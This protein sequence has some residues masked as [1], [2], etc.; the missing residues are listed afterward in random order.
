MGEWLKVEAKLIVYSQISSEWAE[1]TGSE[2]QDLEWGCPISWSGVEERT[3]PAGVVRK[4]ET[5][6]EERESSPG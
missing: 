3:M 2:A 1:T 6:K 4:R 5:R